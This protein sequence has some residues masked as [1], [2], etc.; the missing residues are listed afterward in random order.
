VP[1]FDT[2]S[3]ASQLFWFGVIFA[4][5]YFVVIRPTLPK[6]GKVMDARETQ[7]ASDLDRAEQAKGAADGIR[8]AHEAAMKD[9]QS[10]AQAKVNAAR[11]AAAKAAEARL[12]TLN[13]KLEADAE[14]AAATLDA[15]RVAARASL[16]ATVAE[17]TS[18]AVGKLAGIDITPAEVAK[19]LA[20][21]PV[22]PAPKSR[23]AKA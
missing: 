18:D 14:A 4:V 5:L 16:T 2:T 3:F 23:S 1:Q 17:L 10:A 13:A 19:A 21:A 12:K 6:V 20:P 15:A 9:A 11:E 7:V 8:T 22:K